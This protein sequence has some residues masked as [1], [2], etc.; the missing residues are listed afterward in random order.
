MKVCPGSNLQSYV[1]GLTNGGVLE[2]GI[3]TYTGDITINNNSVCIYG[4]GENTVIN[5]KVTVAAAGGTELRRMS[6]R[7]AGAAWG[8]KLHA[9]GAEVK[10]GIYEMLNIGATSRGAGNGPITGVIID[11]GILS[12]FHRVNCAFCTGDGFLI[13]STDG[14]NPNT[15]T[16]FYNC[17]AVANELFG[18]HIEGSL[19]NCNWEG[20]NIEQN[21]HDTAGGH[22]ENFAEMRINAAIAVMVNFCDFETDASGIGQVVFA[23]AGGPVLINGCNFTLGAGASIFNAG[24]PVGFSS[25]SYGGITNNY[26]NGFPAG[27]RLFQSDENSP[28]CYHFGNRSPNAGDRYMCLG[29]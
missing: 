10:R 13:D 27:S 2:L 21:G 8:L 19:T 17:S 11:G 1:D 22:P 25:V 24:P 4:Q 29:N 20:G 3:G 9:T 16:H 14:A 26:F 6:I 5:G 23:S 15:T 7:S 28:G 18:V 12:D